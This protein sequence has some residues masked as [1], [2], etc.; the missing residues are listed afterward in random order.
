MLITVFYHQ[1]KKG[2]FKLFS[3]LQTVFLR[4]TWIF[5]QAFYCEDQYATLYET[6]AHFP[7]STYFNIP[8]AITT[9]CRNKVANIWA[10]GI[11]SISLHQKTQISH[12]S[13]GLRLSFIRALANYPV[14]PL[15]HSIQSEGR[16]MFQLHA[17]L[18]T[19]CCCQYVL[20]SNFKFI[21]STRVV[22]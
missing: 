10:L 22:L 4:L 18:T 21:I 1:P 2:L 14:V 13:T 6:S 7:T 8:R 11:T 15:L 12:L 9:L 5:H 19:C 17:G 3:L 16:A 20:T